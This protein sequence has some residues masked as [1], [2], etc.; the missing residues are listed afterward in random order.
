MIQNNYIVGD[1]T[2]YSKNYHYRPGISKTVVEN[3]FALAQK[4]KE[5]YELKEKDLVVDIGSND[6]TLLNQFK[7]LSIKNL[8][9]IDLTNTI[10]FQKKIGIK[11]LQKFFNLKSSNIVK[12][13]VGKAKVIIT[14]NVFAHSNNMEDFIKGVKNLISKNGVFCN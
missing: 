14:T 9:G 7:K 2:L 12:S 10:K 13:K 8:F 6:G 11:S 4:I 3:Q 5:I 1:N